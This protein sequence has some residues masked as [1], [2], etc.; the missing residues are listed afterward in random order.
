MS[1]GT[2]H[3]KGIAMHHNFSGSFN[4]R[5]F[6]HHEEGGAKKVSTLFKGGAK[7]CTLSGCM[8]V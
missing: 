2:D 7:S 4:M 3:E 5:A 1:L 8:N 6:S